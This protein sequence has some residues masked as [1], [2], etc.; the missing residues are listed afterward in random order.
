MRQC[1]IVVD[2]IAGICDS[3]GANLLVIIESLRIFK[4]NFLSQFIL[5]GDLN[6]AFGWATKGS[7]GMMED[8]AVGIIQ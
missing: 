5:E 2:E 1:E 7:L 4:E 8:V 3:N 6:I